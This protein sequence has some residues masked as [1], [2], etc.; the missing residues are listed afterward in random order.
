[1]KGIILA[2]GSGT[3][4]HPITRGVSKQ[5]LPVY[6]KPM[7]Y[8]PLSVLML[9]GIREVLII[10][11][12]EDLP[13][14]RNLL[15]DGSS[16]GI[17]LQYAEQPTPDGLAQAFIIG[18][19]FI[20]DSNV[21]LVLGDNI[22]YKYAGLASFCYWKEVTQCVFDTSWQLIEHLPLPKG[23]E[24]L[25]SD[26]MDYYK[27]L[28]AAGPNQQ[29]LLET[30]QLT[31]HY[32]IPQWLANGMP[33]EAATYQYNAPQTINTALDAK[34]HAALVDVM[35]SRPYNLQHISKF[36]RRVNSDWMKRS[37]VLTGNS[38]L[39]QEL[40]LSSKTSHFG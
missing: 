23:F 14:F 24:A 10:S 37:Q 40:L 38:V 29:D 25:W 3:R 26:A 32:N 9:A 4:L 27:Q 39:R 15:G 11:T 31:L 2:G 8:Y 12:P 33:L 1:M 5:L 16:F 30:A 22:F 19:S 34:H 21:A 6:D 17:E 36:I 18:E 7:I 35:K 13:N 20:G 28:Y